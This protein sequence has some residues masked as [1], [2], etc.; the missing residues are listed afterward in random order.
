MVPG[1]TGESPTEE[2]EVSDSED[3]AA[4]ANLLLTDVPPITS[5]PVLLPTAEQLEAVKEAALLEGYQPVRL[6]GNRIRRSAIAPFDTIP[7]AVSAICGEAAA[8][9]A[10]TEEAARA[11]ANAVGGAVVAGQSSGQTA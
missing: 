9:A 2:V 4:K 6:Q 1:R 10:A 8:A 11:A 5:T 7:Q 3:A